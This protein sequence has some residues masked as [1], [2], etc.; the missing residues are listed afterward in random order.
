MGAV[1]RIL[2]SSY[3][4]VDIKEKHES[5]VFVVPIPV[6]AKFRVV[7]TEICFESVSI[8]VVV[9]LIARNSRETLTERVQIPRKS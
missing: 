2:N 8:H 3:V 5:W 4:T 1:Y 9:V 6:S 7:L